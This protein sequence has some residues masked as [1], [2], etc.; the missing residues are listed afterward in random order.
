MKRRIS[1]LFA[2]MVCCFAAHAKVF[3]LD[4][5]AGIKTGRVKEFVISDLGTISELD[6]N[7][8]V[9][10]FMQAA[11][12]INVFNAV[13]DLSVSSAIPVRAGSAEDYDWVMSGIGGIFG[14]PVQYSTHDCYLD[15]MFTL[16]AKTGYDFHIFSL[17]LL[18]EAGIAYRNQKFSARNGW[19]QYSTDGS[20]ITG[21][22]E[23]KYFSGTILSYEQQLV[24]PFVSL[25]AEYTFLGVL[26]AS[27]YG[28]VY[29]Y[30]AADSIDSHYTTKTQYFD[31]MRGGFGFSVGTSV[32]YRRFGLSVEYEYMKCVSGSSRSAN[33]GEGTPVYASL[34]TTPGTDLSVWTFTFIYRCL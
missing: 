8:N 5:S 4:A 3:T 18:P 7:T 14:Y 6:W 30:L 24:L 19:G 21:S 27:L 32:Q 13:L 1:L 31:S 34:A 29:P 15:K 22:T 17:S 9:V 12:R 10:P 33:L 26:S 23:K 2:V 11:G 25:E 20:P 16:E 28:R